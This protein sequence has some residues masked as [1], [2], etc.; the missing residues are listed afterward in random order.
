MTPAWLAGIQTAPEDG[1]AGTGTVRFAR[2]APADEIPVDAASLVLSGEQ[3]NTSM[4]F[5][6]TAI[7]KFFRRLQ[8]GVNPDIEVQTELS[9]LGAANIAK[10]L[11]SIETDIDGV[12]SSL[13]FLQQYMTSATD[14]W[15]AATASVRDLMAEADLHADEAGGDFAGESERLGAAVAK[16][17]ADL[18]AAFGTRKAT[19]DDLQSRSAAMLERLRAALEIVPQLGEIAE[20]LGDLF[21]EVAGL[22]GGPGVTMQRIHG[23]LHLGQV[24]RTVYR[25]VLIDFEG[26]PMAAHSAAR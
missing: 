20:P 17:H 15:V 3:S 2:Y 18:A 13:A 9:R 24:L 5:G 22:A 12:A 25:W 21:R 6:D 23:D 1:S 10:M 14:G 11:G 16:T 26:E 19:A 4:I 8:P 7:M